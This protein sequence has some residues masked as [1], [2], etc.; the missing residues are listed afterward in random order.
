MMGWGDHNDDQDGKKPKSK[1][2]E[3]EIVPRD[4]TD[5]SKV[6]DHNRQPALTPIGEMGRSFIAQKVHE[7]RRKLMVAQ[8][9]AEQAAIDL[10]EVREKLIETQRYAN[11]LDRD[12]SIIEDRVKARIEEEKARRKIVK[13][14]NDE[15]I[16]S[17]REARDRAA[18]AAAKAEAE[19]NEA[20]LKAELHNTATE[21]RREAVR[22]G[23]YKPDK[24]GHRWRGSKPSSAQRAEKEFQET[25]NRV[26]TTGFE[27]PSE[28]QVREKELEWMKQENVS[29]RTLLPLELQHRLE[30]MYRLARE[31][32]FRGGST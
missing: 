21:K 32:K 7:S 11:L 14:K 23:T 17:A 24:R 4:R 27:H 20:L 1:L 15:E 30:Q 16:L 2:L 5:V 18:A 8:R 10:A 25:L 19:K 28:A 12:P 29:D 22:D 9:E 3:G 26:A 13:L 31:H 6:S